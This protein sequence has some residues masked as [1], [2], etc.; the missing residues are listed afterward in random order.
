MKFADGPM[1]ADGSNEADGPMD[2]DVL[3]S[4]R[5]RRVLF[6]SCAKQRA[7]PAAYPTQPNPTTDDDQKE[8]KKTTMLSKE[9]DPKRKNARLKKTS[10]NR[11]ETGGVRAVWAV[12][13]R[14]NSEFKP[15][16]LAEGEQ[17]RSS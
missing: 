5:C 6:G 11:S 4:P 10:R 12:K 13:Q 1:D 8:K 3:V 15:Y 9:G 17:H 16:S 7:G 14:V 2:A